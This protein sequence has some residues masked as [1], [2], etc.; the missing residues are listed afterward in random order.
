M[1]SVKRRIYSFKRHSTKYEIAH[2]FAVCLHNST[3]KVQEYHVLMLRGG[4]GGI[5]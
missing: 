5:R 2:K 4:V 3:P 1:S